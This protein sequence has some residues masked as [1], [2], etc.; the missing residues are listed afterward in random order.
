MK[1]SFKSKSEWASKV[2]NIIYPRS[3]LGSQ[4]KF[5]RK[6][7]KSFHP[8]IS[9]QKYICRN[10]SECEIEFLLSYLAR[11]IPNQCKELLLL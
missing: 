8:Q 10:L 5:S 6:I 1:L 2:E 9:F 4:V 11:K 3:E 7:T